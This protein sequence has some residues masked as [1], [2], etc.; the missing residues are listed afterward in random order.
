MDA[1]ST[2]IIC[3]QYKENLV[4]KST[5]LKL[6]HD[7]KEHIM[8]FKGH[9]ETIHKIIYRQP[10]MRKDITIMSKVLDFATG[11]QYY[12]LNNTSSIKSTSHSN[13]HDTPGGNSKSSR[14]VEATS[15][16]H[17]IGQ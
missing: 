12:S 11:K 10:D 17:K 13:I 6:N 15:C 16:Q 14:V 4:T 1:A 5:S 7:E 2:K 8:N 9:S 3:N